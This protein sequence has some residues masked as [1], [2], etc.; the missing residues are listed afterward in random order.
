MPETRTERRTPLPQREWICPGPEWP[1]DDETCGTVLDHDGRCDECTRRRTLYRKEA[2][3]ARRRL[4]RRQT[5][6]RRQAA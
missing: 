1:P 6:P 3:R 4:Q 5:Q 2:A